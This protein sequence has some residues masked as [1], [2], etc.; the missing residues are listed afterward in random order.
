MKSHR[1]MGSINKSPKS[2]TEPQVLE[3]EIGAYESDSYKIKWED[4]KLRL[5][6][7]F[8]HGYFE[9]PGVLEPEEQ[10]WEEFWKALD[11]I[12]IWDW[13]SE[14]T[15]PVMDGTG[16]SLEIMQGKQSIDTHGHMA[17]PDPNELSQ[18]VELEETEPFNKLIR[19]LNGLCGKEVIPE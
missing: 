2:K 12:K 10:Q 4:G 7:G 8:S 19:A 11:E 6:S 9:E 14:Y 5:Y 18:A 1:I 13:A 15:A 17:W 16:W 3:F